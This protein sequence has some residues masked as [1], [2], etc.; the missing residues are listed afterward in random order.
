LV[1]FW[2]FRS[3]SPL[4]R[5]GEFDPEFQRTVQNLEHQMDR[6][7]QAMHALTN[8]AFAGSEWPSLVR[9]GAQPI[10][11]ALNSTMARRGVTIEHR[12]I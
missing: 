4:A 5:R 3:A 2:W 11:D 1:L 7:M 9:S 8:T 6:W 12:I 10:R